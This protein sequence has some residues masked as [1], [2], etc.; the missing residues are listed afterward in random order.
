MTQR[1]IS[2]SG[3]LRSGKDAAADYLVG[4]FDFVKMGMSDVLNDVMMVLNPW[5]DLDY[6][7]PRRYAEVVQIYGYTEAKKDPEVRRLL[8]VLG[9][10][11]GRNMLGENIWVDSMANRIRTALGEGEDVVVTGVRFP[12]ELQMIRSLGG[13]PVWINRPSEQA[14]PEHAAH[15]SE[16][17]LDA[18]HF[19]IQI[20][21][22]GT[23]EDL[24]E[25]VENMLE[26]EYGR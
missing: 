11:I 9:T 4:H 19:A 3:A 8:Q 13:K 18:T 23:L 24:Y 7:R 10:E 16:R 26:D 1:L 22:I 17:S 12:N 14:A 25:D 5:T 15:A 2:F 6:E 20:N 21:N